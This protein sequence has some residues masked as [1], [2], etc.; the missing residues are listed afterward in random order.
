MRSDYFFSLSLLAGMAASIAVPGLFAADPPFASSAPR[1]LD[2]DGATD[3][4]HQWKRAIG[5][6]STTE[7]AKVSALPGFEVELVRAAQPG[8]DSWISLEFDPQGRLFIGKEG[9][10]ILRFELPKDDKPGKMEVVDDTLLEPRGLLWAHNSLYVNA[11]NSKGLYRLR[12]QEGDGRFEEVKPLRKTEGGVGHGRNDLALGPD[13]MIYLIHGNDVQLP[14]D[15]DKRSS[16]Y[17]DFARDRLLPCTWDNKL[18]EFG[19][20]EPAGHVIRTDAEGKRWELFCG[21]MRNAYGIAFNAEG[22]AFTYDSDMEWDFGAPWYRP[23]RVT[24]LVSGADYGFRQGTGKWAAYYPD[25]LPP[26]VDIGRGSP[27]GVK[28]G[29]KSNFPREFREA[30]YVLDWA[31]GRIIAVLNKPFGASYSSTASVFLKGRPLNVTDLEFG[32]D[33]HMYF[34]TGGRRTQSGLY[35]VKY[36]GPKVVDLGSRKVDLVSA[37]KQLER[38][39][40]EA[41]HGK[42]DPQAIQAAWPYL[43]DSDRWLRHAARVAI[44]S[45]PVAAWQEKALSETDK[46]AGPLALLALARLAPRQ[47]QPQLLKRL[48]EWLHSEQSTEQRLTALRAMTVSFCRH[49]RPE[50]S[51]GKAMTAAL[52]LLYPAPL[53]ETPLNQELC[54]LLVYLHSPNVIAKTLPLLDAAPTQEEKLHYLY[55]L[56]HVDRGWSLDQR[57]QLLAWLGKARQFNGAQDMPKFIDNTQADHLA[58]FTPEERRALRAPI[59]ALEKPKPPEASVIGRKLIR[60]YTMTDLVAKL[61]EIDQGRNAERGRAMYEAALCSRCHRLAAQGTAHGPDLTE[62]ARRFGRRDILLSILEPSR[63][64]DDKHRGLAIA[65][66]DGKLISGA[67]VGGDEEAVVLASEPLAP[68]KTT[69]IL[70]SEIESQQPSALSPMPE[71]LLSTLTEDEILDLLA[72]IE[73]GGRQDHPLFSPKPRVD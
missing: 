19:V 50:E 37:K 47:V 44:E 72:W 62:V 3:D 55:M 27:T 53:K 26:Q 9:K 30:L 41:F 14:A 54:E 5:G 63:A 67:V 11:N 51:D 65:T 66:K 13:G 39:D 64:I 71:G 10:G 4:Y 15:Y 29:T 34:T 42:I 58:T 25:S 31:Y 8:E 52:E 17:R 33:G 45:Q 61:S 22:E 2:A 32:P 43:S 48:A 49:G 60:N 40:L 46:T 70:K 21:G 7:A 18:F 1:P 20:K 38:R 57:K 69:R 73:A 59:A 28:F 35:R 16:P 56:R 36:V 23:T 6:G 24:H 68:E 12:D